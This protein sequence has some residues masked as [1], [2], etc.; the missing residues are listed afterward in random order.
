MKL[1][2][3]SSDS[4]TVKGEVLGYLTGILYLRPNAK[5]CPDHSKGCMASCLVSAGRGNFSNVKASRLRK[6]KEFMENPTEFVFQ[7]SKD[8]D[9]VIRK[10][11]RENLRPVIRLNGT[12][13]IAWEN[14]RVNT[15]NLFEAYPEVQ[16][17]DYTKSLQRMHEFLSGYM[18]DNYHLTFS[19][20]EDTML[21]DVK[22]ILNEG[23][24][25]AVVHSYGKKV[26]V[27]TMLGL[28]VISGDNDDLRFLDPIGQLVGLTAKGKARK[29]KSGFV[30]GG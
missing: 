12:S 4:K 25:V 18:P 22:A 3:V 30:I 13:D 7:L 19:R 1:L 17:Y 26:N 14:I 5:L 16:F 10:A 11:K 8:I 23:G 28:P 9:A 24:N 29:D 21:E 20:D 27:K 2:S 6:T 15:L